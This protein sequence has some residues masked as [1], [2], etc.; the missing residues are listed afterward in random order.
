MTWCSDFLT[1]RDELTRTGRT[2]VVGERATWLMPECKGVKMR[3]R[4]S[5]PEILRPVFD[6][7][8]ARGILHEA[9]SCSAPA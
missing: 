8:D 5:Q 3:H 7:R 6:R 4:I 2:V 9:W 1:A